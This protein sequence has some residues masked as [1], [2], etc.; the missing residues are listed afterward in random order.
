M[1]GPET[2]HRRDFL[3]RFTGSAAALGIVR[4]LGGCR[5]SASSDRSPSVASIRDQ[6]FLHF[7]E[8]NPVVS[9]YLGGDG[10]DP[11]LA[12]I[13]GK[14]RDYRP[15]ALATERD[16]YR[17]IRAELGRIDL[18]SL[19]T[20]DRIDHAV[21]QAQLAFLLHQI[22]DTRHF[23]RAI[24]TYVAEPFRGIDWQLQ[25]MQRI[26]GTVL[27]TPEE[28]DLVVARLRSVPSYLKAAQ[29]N[30]ESG[31]KRGNIPDWRMVQ[32]DGLDG[33][34]ANVEY[35]DTTLPATAKG[36]LGSRAFAPA[37]S[38][39]L[40]KSAADAARAYNDF[41][42]FLRTSFGS[43]ERVDRFAAGE[44]E[45]QWRV[46]H[47]LK[48]NRTTDDLYQ[49]GADQVELYQDRIYEVA[50]EVA[51]QGKLGLGFDSPSEKVE[52][53]RK[54]MDHLAADSP[55]ND[56]ELFR[57]YREV[58]ARAVAY[59]REHHLF[60]IP[61]S[62]QLDVVA[63]PPVL[64]TTIDAAY[65]PAPPFKHSGVGRFYL[66]P[67]GNDPAALR[68]NNRASVAD[69]AVHEGFPGHDWHYKYMTQH[70]RKISNIRWLTPGAVEDSSSMWEDSMAAE[71]WALYSEELMAE[72]ATER[73]HGFYTAAEHL[74]ELQ[75]Q[76]LRAV[77]V[78]V[79]VGIHTGRMKFDQALD[80][81]TE[82][83]S[84]YPHACA[85]A[86]ADP[87]ARAICQGAQRA[88]YRYSKWP[89]QAITYN[90]GK[91]AIVE[92]RDAYRAQQGSA[93]SAQ[94][95][96]ERLM[97]MGTIPAGYF[98]DAFLQHPVE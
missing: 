58:G 86:G 83:V 67:T 52:S 35:F 31:K 16:L 4:Q 68:L 84:F 94:A 2:M 18:R 93:Y 15:E 65:Y 42:A 59:G 75:G 32:R 91:S 69:T 70:A 88:L 85:R 53:V 19:N 51:S 54:V 72:P 37:L 23:E 6:Y 90:L 22:E 11:H 12:G 64:R 79:D 76:L 33:A 55:A 97:G 82:H 1:F 25:Q 48:V 49:Y 8:L 61:K 81:F 43:E 60:Q 98:R 95:F 56:D 40:E 63:T 17:R 24:D 13:N 20:S 96:H 45:Y 78:R 73:P 29:A 47:C 14:L 9:T 92:L 62:Y 7:L 87:A 57:W 27:G 39:A 28:W 41:S 21:L 44:A 26:S 80:Y 50:R 74:Y 34:K 5:P 30:L 10:Y 89:T 71:G 38:R 3:H 66:T 77:R 46:T 36:Y